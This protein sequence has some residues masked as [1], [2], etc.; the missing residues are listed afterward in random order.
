MTQTGTGRPL[1]LVTGASSGIGYALADQFAQHGYDLVIAAEDGGL[2]EA[3]H[4]LE[5]H[6]AA[7]EPVQVDLATA[8][9]VERLYAA[10]TAR[11]RHPDAVAINAGTGVGGDFA[12]GSDL[13]AELRLV[14]LNVRSTVHLAK[15]VTAD[16]AARGSGRIL[17][18]SSIAG[19]MPGPFE[20]VYAASKA[21]DLSFA[22]ALRNE[23]KDTG[24]TVTALMPGPTDTN[25]FDRAGLQDTKL[26]QAKKDDPAAVAKDGFE[27][28]MAGKDKVVA[29]SAKNKA[30]AA[31]A[32]VLPDETKAALHRKQSEP[33]SASG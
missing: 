5:S 11:G 1:A 30:Q 32:R 20:A 24:V 8:E 27:A 14:D 15:R 16:M 17:I 18:T 23:L 29:G 33:G 26:G 7:V 10:A 31:A 6:G 9:G 2:A 13:D 28:L 21:F 25:F 22:E 4:N 12:R 19:T 3:A